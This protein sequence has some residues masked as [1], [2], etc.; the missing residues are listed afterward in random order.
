MPEGRIVLIVLKDMNA[1]GRQDE[2]NHKIIIKENELLNTWNTRLQTPYPFIAND[3]PTIPEII[4]EKVF[5]NEINLNWRFFL[6]IAR[7]IRD[8]DV[9]K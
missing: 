3:M 2:K 1:R 8:V 5:D 4:T 6:R 7:W 9:N